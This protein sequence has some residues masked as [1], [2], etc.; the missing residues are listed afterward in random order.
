M[1]QM[2]RAVIVARQVLSHLFCLIGLPT[3]G[4]CRDFRHVRY[5]AVVL[6]RGSRWYWVESMGDAS[7]PIR[8]SSLHAHLVSFVCP[9][10][11]PR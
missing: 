8:K 3:D 10:R 7:Q 1:S 6:V 9:D 11:I 4:E 5:V 2:V